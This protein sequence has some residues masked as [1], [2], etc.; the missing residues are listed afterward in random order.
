MY[1]IDA[2]GATVNINKD[3]AGYYYKHDANFREGDTSD[4]KFSM[5]D[6]SKGS[7]SATA[8]SEKKA[9][10]I[11][12]LDNANS[13]LNQAQN[14][15]DT[16]ETQYNNLQAELE[17][18][19]QAKE[20]DLAVVT[21]GL[22]I[23]GIEIIPDKAV[24]N[25]AD[26]P[27]TIDEI[28]HPEDFQD[29]EKREELVD[30]IQNITNGGLNGAAALYDLIGLDTADIAALA[31]AATVGT[32]F[33]KE[34][35]KAWTDALTAKANVI[36]SGFELVAQAGKTMEA[37]K[38]LLTSGADAT[39]KILEV[40]EN[41]AKVAGYTGA[42]G[43][44]QLG[45]NA[46]ELT[47]QVLSKLE[48]KVTVLQLE[49]TAAAKEVSA[50]KAE[51]DAMIRKGYS[52]YADIMQDAK[53][54][55]DLAQSKYDALIKDLEK[56]NTD[57]NVAY[58]RIGAI[59]APQSVTTT[60]PA[61]GR[62]VLDEMRFQMLDANKN[63]LHFPYNVVG[64]TLVLNVNQVKSVIVIEVA[65]MAE[66]VNQRI[67]VLEF[68]TSNG[69]YVLDMAAFLKAHPEVLGTLEIDLDAG[70]YS[71]VLNGNRVTEKMELKK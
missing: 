41:A 47:N 61:T 44:V 68:R 42:V 70:T 15:Y 34:Y 21:P 8:Y 69:T 10:A 54:R 50:A 30:A 40:A 56:A 71:Y 39:D 18:M 65:Y 59:S 17:K 9:E 60:S 1:Y 22:S 7:D 52:P 29:P 16:A 12:N 48:S 38:A 57:L 35:A 53:A 64:N 62:F 3:E 25:L 46:L 26:L 2:N 49:T 27:V 13:A 19:A 51:L 33:Q 24:G 36:I 63:V 6:V 28:L 14:N 55:L 32:D 5:T 31:A 11:T 23:G 45:D 43:V 67:E 4:L 37:G 58:R 66:L 20:K